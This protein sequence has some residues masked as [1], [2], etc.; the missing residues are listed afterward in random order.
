MT[1]LLEDKKLGSPEAEHE[2][3]FEPCPKRVRVFSGAEVVADSRRVMTMFETGHLPVYYFPLSD[4]RMDLLTGSDHHSTCPYKGTASYFSVKETK[5]SSEKENVAWTYPEPLPDAPAE[6]S[7]LV[8]FY[9]QKMDAWFEEDEEVY[10]H[11]RDPYKRVDVLQS[12]RHVQVEVAGEIVADTHRPCLV[13][14]TYL[15]TRYYIPKLDVRLDLLEASEKTTQCP[16]KGVAS[17]Y[18]VRA[19][20]KLAEDIAWYYPHP[21]P[22]CAKIEN[23]VCFF[24]EKVDAVYVDGE[25]AER[26]STPW[27]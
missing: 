14:E 12:S 16:Y 15:P 2:V 27:S 26:P 19:G 7:E 6:L 1:Q 22:E 24:D 9:W 20:G 17:Y 3:R 23:F 11:P 10:V 18:S 13:F 8:A 25:R 5:G 4:V 21:T